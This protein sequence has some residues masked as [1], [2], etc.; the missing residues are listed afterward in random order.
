M[1]TLSADVQTRY[2]AQLLINLTNSDTPGNTTSTLDT[3]RLD[4]AATD[5]EADFLTY[6]GVT[7]DST[8]ASHVAVAV[9]GVIA[10][11]KARG[12]LLGESGR[13]ALA[14]WR[15]SL[16][17]NLG[18]ISGRNRIMPTSNSETTTESELRD[19]E[20]LRPKF[21]WR[22]FEGIQLDDPR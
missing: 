18:R 17:M 15:K 5:I 2:G 8:N 11:L 3:T 4:A 20:T 1:A 10:L 7:Y 6:A 19:G 16:S 12:P 22:S 9:E 14:D 21:G 13:D